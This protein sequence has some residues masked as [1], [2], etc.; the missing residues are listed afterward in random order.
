MVECSKNRHLLSFRCPHREIR[1]LHPVETR[2][3]GSEFVIQVE[4]SALIK[5][6][7]IVRGEEAAALWGGVVLRQE[8]THWLAS[9]AVSG[10]IHRGR[11]LRLRVGRQLAVH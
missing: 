4:M 11:V 9:L 5:E 7:Q 1:P 2:G 8:R 3:M 10:V 6:V